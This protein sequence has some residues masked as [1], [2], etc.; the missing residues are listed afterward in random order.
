[1][2]DSVVVKTKPGVTLEEMT[3]CF[4][5][6]VDDGLIMVWMISGMLCRDGLSHR[7]NMNRAS[8]RTCKD[9]RPLE[10]PLERNISSPTNRQFT[11][12]L[13]RNCLL[14]SNARER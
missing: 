3:A 13:N 12:H 1:M 7:V 9:K 5:G 14:N 2:A 6:G 10:K 4:S 8:K 11:V